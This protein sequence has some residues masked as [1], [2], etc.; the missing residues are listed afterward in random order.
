MIESVFSNICLCALSVLTVS[1]AFIVAWF[2]YGLL[3]E[4][5]ESAKNKTDKDNN[6]KANQ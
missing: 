5:I 4:I 6:K 2:A 1:A 3:M